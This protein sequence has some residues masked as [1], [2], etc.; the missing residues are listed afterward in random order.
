MKIPT[1]AILVGVSLYA[2]LRFVVAYGSIFSAIVSFTVGL[3]LLCLSSGS[4]S[5]PRSLLMKYLRK[6]KKDDSGK[7]QQEDEAFLKALKSNGEIV[8]GIQMIKAIETGN[9][10]YVKNWLNKKTTQINQQFSDGSTVLH[11]AAALHGSTEIVKVLLER[12]V[13]I[14]A[15]DNECNTA[16]HLAALTGNAMVVKMLC[17]RGMEP[18]VQNNLGETPIDIAEK[19]GNRGCVVLMKRAVKVFEKS[20]DTPVKLR[21][22]SNAV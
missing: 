3:S 10:T 15:A 22:T 5:S 13:D 1:F 19:C 4:S 16:L 7:N 11:R 18:L 12:G 17:D 9:V 8:D 14:R 20:S 21:R 6:Y 2:V